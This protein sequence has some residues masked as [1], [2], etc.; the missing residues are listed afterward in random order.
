MTGACVLPPAQ[1]NPE[2]PP[3]HGGSTAYPV[4]ITEFWQK[5]RDVC[6]GIERGMSSRKFQTF[7]QPLSRPG[8][9][10]C[11]PQARQEALLILFSS[12]DTRFQTQPRR[13][14]RNNGKLASSLSGA[15][16]VS[17]AVPPTTTFKMSYSFPRCF[18]ESW[19]E[20]QNHRSGFYGNDLGIALKRSRQ[21]GASRRLHP[22][23]NL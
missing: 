14:Q 3:G 10:R 2:T 1:Q 17:P 8:W 5:P 12:K 20:F 7:Q 15:S 9:R 23:R 11:L 13:E 16:W 4:D 6:I 19:T 22:D 18:L 21:L